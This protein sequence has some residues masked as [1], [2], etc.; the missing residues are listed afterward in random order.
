MRAKFVND[1]TVEKILDHIKEADFND[2]DEIIASRAN[3]FTGF[4]KTNSA[5]FKS[6]MDP[7]FNY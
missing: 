1:T 4:K 5:P 7:A 3:L 6:P 2:V